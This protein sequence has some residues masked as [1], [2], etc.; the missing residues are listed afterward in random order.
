MKKMVFVILLCG[1]LI[2]TMTGCVKTKNKLDI[3]NKSNIKALKNDVIMTIK[4]GTLTNKSVTL[5][6]INNSDKKIQYGSPYEIEIKKNDEW[7]K[8]NAELNF[9][10]QLFILESKE[11]NEF[12]LNFEDGYGKLPSGTYRVIKKIDKEKE[13]GVFDSFYVSTEFTIK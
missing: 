1:V 3:G 8:I 4:D 11:K 9:T 7:H 10:L 2:L 6:L 13:D 12:E 5:V